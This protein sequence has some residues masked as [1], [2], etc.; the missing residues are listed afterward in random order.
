M[1]RRKAASPSPPLTGAVTVPGDKSISHRTLIVSG[2]AAGTS[3]IAG[4]NTGEDV[5]ATA[6]AMAALGAAVTIA[7]DNAE[8]QGYGI[9]GL[10][11]PDD[12]ID[13]GNS[14]TSLRTL[15]GVC[16]GVPGVSVLT[17]DESLRTRPMLRVAAP[18]R[19]M[20]ARVDGRL[21]GELPP[22]VV[23]GGDLTGIDV[24]L[25]VPSAQVKT[26]LL[27]A[28][29]AARGTTAVTEPGPSRDHTERMLAA[30]G[31][32]VERAG[33]TCALEG[34][35]A[36]RPMSW[37]VPGDTSSALYLLVAALLVPGSELTVR[38]VLLNPTRTAAFDVLRRMG[39]DLTVVEAGES[40]GEPRGDVSARTS[41][42]VATTIEPA[43]VPR[44]IDDLP[45]LGIAASQAA[46]RT[47]VRGAAEL[48]VKESDRIAAL[49]EGLVAIGAP[50]EESPDG[51]A[52]EG[53]APIAGG[54]VDSRGDHRVAMSFALAGLVSAEGV[55]VGRWS[56]V[57]T[58]FPGFLDVLGQ[59]QGR[60]VRRPG[61]R[62]EP[63]R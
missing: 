60:I 54:A 50:A 34:G 25:D 51:F 47:E 39:A 8:V 37:D 4:L 24:E 14:G 33:T 12:V 58:S 56:C 15:L 1:K 2:L 30:A 18:L 62:D 52:V 41:E 20:G 32:P 38:N 36:P 59:A 27:L 19:Q 45:A 49:V 6:R 10:R 42:L 23:R 28:G 7:D 44:L 29:L 55:R 5:A 9:G 21:H 43:E 35:A 53:P 57:D 63:R 16:A 31:V 13:A 3:T 48:R 17:G 46:G 22:M 40:G 26:A 11:E 61:K